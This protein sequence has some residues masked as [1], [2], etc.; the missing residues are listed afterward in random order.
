MQYNPIVPIEF[1][2]TREAVG[3][4]CLFQPHT[5][6]VTF[7][8]LHPHRIQKL[9]IGEAWP[10]WHEGFGRHGEYGPVSNESDVQSHTQRR[11]F[12]LGEESE[13]RISARRN[14]GVNAHP[15]PLSAS[16]TSHQT[17]PGERNKEKG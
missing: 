13:A 14:W 17:P 15:S 16:P 11:L 10:I 4:L 1:M 9:G 2:R 3:R 6:R 7:H 5:S 8:P 12:A